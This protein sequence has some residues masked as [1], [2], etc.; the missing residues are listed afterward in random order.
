M[1]YVAVLL[2][3]VLLSRWFKATGAGFIYYITN[4][5]SFILL[6]GGGSLETGMAY[7]GSQGS[8][9]YRKLAAFSLLWSALV[10]ILILAFLNGTYHEPASLISKREFFLFSSTYVPG[11]LLTTYFCALFSAKQDFITPNL[12]M[13]VIN[14]LLILLFPLGAW[15]GRPD[16]ITTHFLDIFFCSFLVQGL[17][18]CV[19]FISKGMPDA[20][21]GLPGLADL[22]RIVA[23]AGVALM[24]NLIFFLLYRI[25][26]WFINNTCRVCKQGDLGNYI[27]VSKLGQ[28]LLVLPGIVSSAVFP[29]TAGGQREEVFNML[30]TI[31][32]SILLFTGFVCVVL[33]VTGKWLFPFVFGPT[34]TSM[35]LPFV[36]LIPGV[37]A[38][39]AL[40]P[41]V[42]YYS[43]KNKLRVNLQGSLL[44]LALITAGD[45]LLIPRYGITAAALVS[46]TGYVLYYGYV[47]LVFKREYHIPVSGFFYPKRSDFYRLRKL[48]LDKLSA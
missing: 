39:A 11:V 36:L 20:P 14:F 30:E 24:G 6:L 4:Y 43:G 23:Y 42:A 5:F 21:G 38:I 19:A 40:N 48:I 8:I 17:L 27:Q 18:I 26:Y 1:Y 15:L 12:I 32:K 3:N 29:R 16:F 47:L 25:D 46:T 7:Y 31:T 34:F 10:S 2:L 13:L 37:L 9:S 35:Y 33:A 22:R 44:A 41:L 28:L 45:A